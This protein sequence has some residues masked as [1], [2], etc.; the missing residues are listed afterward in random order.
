MTEQPP[1]IESERHKPIPVFSEESHPLLFKIRCIFDLQLKTIVDFLKPELRLMKDNVLDIGTGQSPWTGYL[2]SDVKFVGLD[3]AEAEKFNMSKNKD[4]VYYNGE[5]FPFANSQFA[6]ALC[7][8]VLEHVPNTDLFLSE[9]ARVLKPGGQLLLTVPWSARRHHIP[10]DYYRFT[11]EGLKALLDRHGFVNIQ[12][13]ER[14]NDITTAYNK[15]LILVANLFRNTSLA[16][17]VFSI[18]LACVLLSALFWLFVAAHASLLFKAK[19]STDPLGYSVK[20]EK[21]R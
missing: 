8:E 10:H 21:A 16:S 7:I 5:N 14:G 1:N 12:I 4:V 20:A 11:K 13:H 6:N 19:L 9:T 2:N 18:F 17:F 15:I 3:T